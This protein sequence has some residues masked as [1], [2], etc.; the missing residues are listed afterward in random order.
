MIIQPG[1]K[2]KA[3]TDILFEAKSPVLI[4]FYANTGNPQDVPVAMFFLCR[5]IW[6]YS[7]SYVDF[8]LKKLYYST[9]FFIILQ[10][11]IFMDQAAVGR[12]K[13]HFGDLIDDRM[14][15]GKEFDDSVLDTMNEP[16][17]QERWEGYVK[18]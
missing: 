13:A 6:K 10:E 1:E 7:Y 4:I 3:H 15:S 8:R 17:L 11:R 18:V 5:F 16:D 12:A 14:E 9:S 2:F